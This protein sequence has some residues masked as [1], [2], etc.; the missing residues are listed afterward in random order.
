MD[1]LKTNFE[2]QNEDIIN[3]GF[4]KHNLKKVVVGY[5]GKDY[6]ITNIIT[7]I[8]HNTLNKI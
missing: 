4:N 3:L 2:I 1:N 8:K 7:K 6:D 5:D